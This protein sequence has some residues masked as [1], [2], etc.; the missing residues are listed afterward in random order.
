MRPGLAIIVLWVLWAVSWLLAAGWA[1]ETLKQ[2]SLR[3]QLGYRSLLVLGALVLG[4]L[5]AGIGYV[6]AQCAWRARVLYLL[7]RRR[8]ARLNGRGAALS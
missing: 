1:A 4:L 5:A 3:A 6:L 2:E 8:A 7:R